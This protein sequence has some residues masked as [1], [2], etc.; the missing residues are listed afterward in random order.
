[1]G[2]ERVARVRDALGQDP[3]FPI[4]T[5]TGTNGKG[6]VCAYLEATLIAAGYRVGCYTSP[7]LLR[8]NERVRV[9]GVEAD[10]AALCDAFAQ[11][12]AMRGT[13]SLT[14]FEFGTLAAMQLFLQQ[15]VDVAVL[16]VGL[17]GRLDAVNVYDCDCAVIS[18]IDLD[19]AAWLG[20]TREQVAYEKAGIMRGGRPAVI[21][22]TNI[23]ETLFAVAQQ[24]GARLLLSGKDYTYSGSDSG[25]TVKAGGD[26]LAGLP[27]P[28]MRGSYQLSN[29]AAALVAL[30]CLRARLP[31]D[32]KAMRKGLLNAKVA[33]RFQVLP[34]RPMHILDVGHNPHAV[35]A[36]AG[37]LALLPPGGTRFAV[38]AML[39]DKDHIAVIRAVMPQIDQWYVAGLDG[40]RG[41]S[42]AALA[43]KLLEAGVA[44]EQVHVYAD[45]RQAYQ[46]VSSIAAEND[47]ITTF[48]SFHTVAEVLACAPELSAA[49][50]TGEH[51]ATASTF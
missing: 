36:L 32:I 45:V 6:S 29:A 23:P 27:L 44:A 21:A 43:D 9:N 24:N 39:N 13:T 49:A 31:V 19:H 15:G 34:G 5:V 20:D 12:E 4:I 33:G 14:Y 38:F 37:N 16:E 48:G 10:D 41:M 40:E 26:V 30:W 22:E 1:M 2:L 46:A 42:G 8:Y 35:R 28:A 17:G 50:S 18:S 11:I 25:W 7:H 51:Y 3:A 47:K